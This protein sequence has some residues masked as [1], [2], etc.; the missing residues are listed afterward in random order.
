VFEVFV[1]VA[2]NCMVPLG[3]STVGGAA[4]VRAIEG[5]VTVTAADADIVGFQIEV[6]VTVTV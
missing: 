3:M 2:V 1:T 5:G 4:G 6:A